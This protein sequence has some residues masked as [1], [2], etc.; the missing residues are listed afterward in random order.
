MKAEDIKKKLRNQCSSSYIYKKTIIRLN[1]LSNRWWVDGS[2]FDGFTEYK[3]KKL[4]E[5]AVD[6][7]NGNIGT[8]LH[9]N[10]LSMF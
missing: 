10:Q 8:D 9:P 4:A 6:E 7:K 1:A 3:T 5:K 2:G